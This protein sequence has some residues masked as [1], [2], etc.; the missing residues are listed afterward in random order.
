MLPLHSVPPVP[1][2]SPSRRLQPPGPF[3]DDPTNVLGHLLCLTHKDSLPRSPHDEPPG[4]PEPTPEP[5]PGSIPLAE[6]P[7][8]NDVPQGCPAHCDLRQIPQV[9]APPRNWLPPHQPPHSLQGPIVLG[10]VP[11]APTFL[12]VVHDK[13]TPAPQ[14]LLSLFLPPHPRGFLWDLPRVCPMRPLL[15]HPVPAEA[16]S[17]SPTSHDGRLG[18][19]PTACPWSF[20]A[21]LSPYWRQDPLLSHH[22]PAQPRKY[23]DPGQQPGHTLPVYQQNKHK[24]PELI[25]VHTG[26]S[27]PPRTRNHSFLPSTSQ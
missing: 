1:C 14:A 26:P 6:L 23:Q 15:P 27:P 2:L 21:H 16:W 3:C 22:R 24:L 5:A 11:P 20:L 12:L 9:G 7:M 17:G 18:I 4:H 19:L 8:G 25:H 10:C 13:F